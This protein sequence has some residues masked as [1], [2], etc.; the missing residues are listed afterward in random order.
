MSG[1]RPATQPQPQQ[2][3]QPPS[4]PSATIEHGEIPFAAIDAALEFLAERGVGRADDPK[5]RAMLVAIGL[6]EGRFLYRDQ[7]DPAGALG[8]ATGAWQFERAGG[9]RSVLRHERTRGAAEALCDARGV[10]ANEDAVWRR[11]VED[12]VLAA[13]FAR[14][15]LWS[16]PAPLPRAAPESAAEAWLYYL[17][18]WRPGKPHRHTWDACWSTA[19]EA[20][21]SGE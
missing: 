7:I 18:N 19:L 11:L 20:V 21:A 8:P 9:V 15:L 16:D 10:A 4:Q 6:Q 2:P 3:Q 17:R 5:A 13:G 1:G 12:D 14:L